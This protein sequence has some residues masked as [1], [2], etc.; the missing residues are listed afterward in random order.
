[1][2]SIR[3]NYGL[4]D[5]TKTRAEIEADGA[6]IREAIEAS[7]SSLRT[8]SVPD[9][10]E[11]PLPRATVEIGREGVRSAKEALLAAVAVRQRIVSIENIAAPNES[12][13]P[14]AQFRASQIERARN[15]PALREVV[16]DDGEPYFVPAG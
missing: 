6:K 13:D 3:E 7:R 12:N 2:S 15:N 8:L 11:W 14:V 5:G 16:G 4:E 1:M 10:R 9:Y